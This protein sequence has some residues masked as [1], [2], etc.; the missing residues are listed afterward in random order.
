MDLGQTISGIGERPAAAG[1]GVCGGRYDAV[2]GVRVLAA[3]GV[4]WAHLPGAAG[5][6]FGHAGLIAFVLLSVI[7]Q[8]KGS[9][10]YSF[11]GFIRRRSFRILTPWVAWFLAYAC[12]NRLKGD[13]W[14]PDSEGFLANVLTGPWI[15]LW[16]LP[17]IFLVSPLVYRLEWL[18]RRGNQGIW[19]GAFGL[20]AS[21][22]LMSAA[23]WPAGSFGPPFDQ[24]IQ[25]AA[26]V[27]FG[28]AF[29]K[30]LGVRHPIRSTW[31]VS[32]AVAGLAACGLVRDESPSLATSYAVALALVTIGFTWTLRVPSWFVMLGSLCLGVYLVHPFFISAIGRLAPVREAVWI[33][34]PAVAAASFVA[35]ACMRR[36]RLLAR[37]L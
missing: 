26:A 12:F 4:I 36:N 13:E 24:W 18:S 5:K 31:L 9:A 2:E 32:L 3:C 7:F 22:V 19:I 29:G 17:F 1:E 20:S 37:I 14:F 25:V 8:A 28:L 33:Y 30:A 11:G 23:L 21:L 27:P 34:F 15:G 6:E 16:F 10:R 35:V